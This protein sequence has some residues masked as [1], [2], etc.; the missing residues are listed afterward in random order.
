MEGA[1]VAKSLRICTV[2]ARAG[3]KGFPGKNES[4]IQGYP[5]FALSLLQAKA[6][7]LFDEIVFSS[8]SKQWLEKATQYGAT[9][10]IDRASELASD[11]AGKVPVICDAVQR[12]QTQLGKTFDWCVDLD[13]TSPLRTVED[14]RQAVTLAESKNTSNVITGT[15]AHRSPYFNLVEEQNGYVHVSKG[16]NTVLRR[17][18]A[19]VCYD[20][21][22]SI[23]VWPV[24][25]LLEKQRVFLEQT[26]IY[27][28]P[29]ER[30]RDIDS[31]LDYKIVKFI[32]ETQ[33]RFVNEW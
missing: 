1:E 8:D 4:I 9:Q 3:S 20:M 17:Q 25:T 7:G 6:S 18:D 28:M 27:V 14:I 19:P 29:E 22:A 30:S 26:R 5:L 24:K 31:E 23:Y 11:Q 32:A 15:L 21:N 16:S 10:V 13:V 12:V 33:K 2:C